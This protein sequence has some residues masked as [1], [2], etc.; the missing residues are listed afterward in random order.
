MSRNA[1]EKE[2]GKQKQK[3]LSLF[4][5]LCVFF[6]YE[7]YTEKTSLGWLLCALCCVDKALVVA[8]SFV[9]HTE[10]FHI[11]KSVD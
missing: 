9:L 11:T 4:D 7:E 1:S 3:H 5:A 8:C 6:W 2:K 10:L